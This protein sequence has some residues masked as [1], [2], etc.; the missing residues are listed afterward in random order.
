MKQ[1]GV[2]EPVTGRQMRL[3]FEPDMLVGLPAADR[4]R[5]VIALARV[6]TQAAGIREEAVD[7]RR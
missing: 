5:A 3:R 1:R 4:Q 6:L 2:K 7:D